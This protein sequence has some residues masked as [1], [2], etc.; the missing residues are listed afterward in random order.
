MSATHYVQYYIQQSGGG[1]GTVGRSNGGIGVVYHA[2]PIYQRGRGG[3]GN[4]FS[5]LL[6]HL[7]PL[8]KSGLNAVKQQSIKTGNAIL[9][10]LSENK[11]LKTVLK[12]QS[13]NAFNELK[14]RGVNKLK[15]KFNQAGDG[16]M[17]IKG[18]YKLSRKSLSNPKTKKTKALKKRCGKPKKQRVKSSSS[19][20]KHKHKD[21]FD[22]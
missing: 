6:Q 18:R 7:Q 19:S 9:N 12:E 1:S 5:G 11:S 10:D 22:Q 8:I 2:P 13:Y 4:F 17:S 20:N 14:K 21:I 15:R 3:V 16:L